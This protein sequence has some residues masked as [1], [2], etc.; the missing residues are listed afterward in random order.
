MAQ[1]GFVEI[2]AG[3]ISWHENYGV[4]GD[5]RAGSQVLK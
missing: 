5:L 1:R 4:Q 3:E 2:F